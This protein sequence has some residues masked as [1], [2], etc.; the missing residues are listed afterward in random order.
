MKITTLLSRCQM[1]KHCLTNVL[2]FACKACLWVWP[3]R[4]KLLVKHIL[5]LSVLTGKISN[6]YEKKMIVRLARALQTFLKVYRP[7][8]S[9]INLY[10][11]EFDDGLPPKCPHIRRVEEHAKSRHLL[12]KTSVPKFAKIVLEPAEHQEIC[13]HFYFCCLEAES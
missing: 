10:F 5:H 12:I 9:N 3:P 7:L 2:N 6:I 11:G 1:Y 8:S 13:R 4:Q